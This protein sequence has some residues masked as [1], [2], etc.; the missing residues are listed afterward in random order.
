MCLS[1]FN[2]SREDLLHMYYFIIFV[3][4]FFHF[5]LKLTA[6]LF[7]LQNTVKAKWI[8]QPQSNL[9]SEDLQTRV[10]RNNLMGLSS[11]FYVIIFAYINYLQLLKIPPK[12]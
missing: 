7:F 9:S 2:F 11:Q 5:F 8:H 1:L 3:Q 10:Y 12:I 4:N 6:L